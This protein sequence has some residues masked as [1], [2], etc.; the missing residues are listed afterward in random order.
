MWSK[1]RF[2]DPFMFDKEIHRIIYELRAK[3][4]HDAIDYLGIRATGKMGTSA[5]NAYVETKIVPLVLLEYGNYIESVNEYKPENT[6]R[7]LFSK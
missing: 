1:I 4:G 2:H 7:R 5:R 6:I 3:Y